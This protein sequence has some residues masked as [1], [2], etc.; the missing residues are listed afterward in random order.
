MKRRDFVKKAA[1]ATAGAF[2]APYILP[3]GRLFAATGVRKANHVVFC[4]F[5]GGVRNF[6]SIQ[7]AEGNLMRCILNGTEAIS[8]D[9]AAGMDI[10][11]SSPL[12]LPLQNYGT[13]F[14]DFRYGAGPTGHFN[15]HTCAV[16]GAYNT[17]DLSIKENPLTPTIFEYYRKHNSPQQTA[18]NAWWI[19]NSLG[20]YPALNYSRDAGYGPAYGANFIAPTSLITPQ[21]YN[22]I[23]NPHNFSSQEEAVINNIRGFM[24]N[25]FPLSY[26]D[27][28]AGVTNPLHPDAESLNTFINGLYAL[29]QSQLLDPWNLGINVTNNDIRNVAFAEKVIQQFQPELLVVNM[30]DVDICHTNFTQY[31]NNLR[32]ADYAVA[33]LW[34]TIQSTPGMQNNTILIIAPEHGRNFDHNSLID[35][36]G[37]FAI[38]HTAPEPLQGGDQTARE[39]FCLVVGPQTGFAAHVDQNVVIDASSGHPG[40]SIEIVPTIANILGFDDSIPSG[41]L[42]SFAT[43]DLGNSLI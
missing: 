9:I 26:T 25:N 22:A 10:L 37:R 29:P 16:T 23:G 2:A 17:A 33:H 30:Q 19:S 35:A 14:K 27:A 42:K 7:K 20:P 3:S 34:N 11:P 1:A 41:M 8:A 36:Y 43:C 38:D 18:L 24:D 13:L 5:A 32:K 6:E 4:L 31:C 12:P 28:S 21:A 15:G 39:I 40:E